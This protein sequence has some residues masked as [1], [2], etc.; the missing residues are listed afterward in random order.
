M[1]ILRRAH[2]ART[3]LL[4]VSAV[5]GL[6]LALLAGR[7][8]LAQTCEA[9]RPTAPV[10]LPARG[11]PPPQLGSAPAC[12]AARFALTA[13]TA[14]ATAVALRWPA[15]PGAIA[16][17]VSWG[18]ADLAPGPVPLPPGAAL[19]GVA[20][21]LRL[22]NRTAPERVAGPF[23]VTEL[24]IAG[25]DAG[26]SYHWMVQALGADGAPVAGS[27]VVSFALPV[28]PPAQ[29]TATG[30]GSGVALSWSLVPD[31]ATYRLLAAS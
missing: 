29:L 30:E 4:V 24:T 6:T 7:P 8:L 21:A 23:A 27:G 20:P 17:T 19:D 28:S 15:V 3:C 10:Q 12:A 25:L 13:T 14:G 2:R 26:S 22:L 1:A 9:A 31:A 16:Y 18:Y 11:V 5:Q